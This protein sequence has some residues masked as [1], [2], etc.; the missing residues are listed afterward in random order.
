MNC[1]ALKLVVTALIGVLQLLTHLKTYFTSNIIY[2]FRNFIKATSSV[3]TKFLP[4]KAQPA[5]GQHSH[6]HCERNDILLLTIALLHF[7]I[8]NLK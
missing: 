5:G 1:F 6:R 4:G 2:S 7:F 3:T 8:T